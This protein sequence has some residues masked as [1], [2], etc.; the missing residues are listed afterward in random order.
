MVLLTSINQLKIG[1]RLKIVGKHNTDDYGSVSVKKIIDCG[2]WTEIL[3]N[4]S[5]NC[6]FHF[7]NYLAGKSQWVKEVFVLDGTDKRLKEAK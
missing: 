4:R 2:T 6:Y 1:T 5:K 7:D 3:I